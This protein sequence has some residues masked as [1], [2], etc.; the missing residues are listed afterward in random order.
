MTVRIGEGEPA[1]TSGVCGHSARA[2]NVARL[3]LLSA[4]LLLASCKT[5]SLLC[6][7]SSGLG[8][9]SISSTTLTNGGH[10]IAVDLAYVTDKDAWKTI[11][12]L[13][14]RD[15][16]AMRDQLERDFPK[17]YR[18]WSRELQ[19]GQ[20][21]Q[22][23]DIAAPCNLVGTAIFANYANDGD[24]RQ[25]LRKGRS[26]TLEL[27]PNDFVWAPKRAPKKLGV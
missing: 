26:G 15:Y 24:H 19:A 13:K 2:V 23:T 8:K 18:H 11:S 27:G 6:F 12:K 3:A 9:I 5:P 20:Y 1:T 4:T 7:K 16:F 17:G 25:V 14:A 21:V 22:V 10:P